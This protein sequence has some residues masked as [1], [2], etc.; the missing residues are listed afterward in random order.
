MSARCLVIA[1]LAAALA[2]GASL[3]PAP[4]SAAAAPACFP[5]T[6]FCLQGRFL[7]YWQAHGGLAVNGY[8]LTDEV[9]QQ[10][11]D[12]KVYA[13]QY[14]ERV[15]LEWHPENPAP[16]DILLGQFGRLIHPADPPAARRAGATYFDTTGHN[17]APDVAAYWQANGGL[18]QFGFPL[19]EEIQQRLDDGKVYTVQY[20]E[21]ARFERHPENPPPY[22]IELGQFGR[23]ILGGLP[24]K[25]T[26][27]VSNANPVSN[28]SVIVSAT[29]T[30]DGQGVSGATMA[31][32]WH[33]KTTTNSCSDGPSGDDGVMRC[34]LPIGQATSGYSVKI[35]I[36]VTYQGQT[37]TA[38]TSFT[39]Q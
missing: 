7:A 18:D 34:A 5:E 35:D 39:P 26:A 28:S 15:R 30:K 37:F 20:F 16:Y 9:Q 24:Y 8:P 12:G 4:R 27:S 17:V 21:R 3:A 32:T 25:V 29:L 31:T 36:L 6:G 33:Y 1:V 14:F 22:D 13:V 19:T 38:T 23:R 11:E 10:L 2:V